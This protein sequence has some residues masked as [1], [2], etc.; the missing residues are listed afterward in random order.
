MIKINKIY[1]LIIITM[2]HILASLYIINEPVLAQSASITTSGSV[3]LDVSPNGNG[4]TIESDTVNVITDC[5]TG[6]NLS[7]IAPNG[8][9]LYK[10]EDDVQTGSTAS[11]TAVDGVHALNDSNNSGKWGFTLSDNPNSN[12][13][14]S[15]ISTTPSVIRSASETA[16]E[17][18]IDDTFSVH[19]GVKTNDNV[20]A[21]NYRM[22]N[23]GAIVY[24]LTTDINCVPYSLQYDGNGADNPNGMGTTSD[25]S[26]EK[27]VRQTN[28]DT[29]TELTLLAPNFKK[30]GHGFLGWSLDKNA[31]T[32]FTDKD[33][34]NDPV[35]YGPNETV[36]ITS[37]ILAKAD[38]DRIITMYAVWIPAL[39]DNYNNPIY[40]QNWDNPNTTLVSD[41]CST[42][43]A[44]TFNGTTG[45]ITPGGI[46]A[47]TDMRDNEVY[48]VAKLAD[49]ECWM[50]E[51]LRLNDQ[52]TK[53]QNQNDATRTNESLAQGYESYDPTFGFAYGSFVGLAEPESSHYTSDSK[54]ENSIYYTSL[55]PG[56][57]PA[58][59]DIGTITPA[60]RFPRYNNSNTVNNVD[61]LSFVQDY[62]NPTNPSP[63]RL[64]E[65]VY[66]YGNYY[67]WSAARA[68]TFPYGTNH[69]EFSDNDVFS[70]CPQNWALPSST[71]P[72]WG[73]DFS[74]LSQA[75]GGT[76]NNQNASGG[77]DTMSKRMRSFPNN[78]MYSGSIG[79][80]VFYR[81]YEGNYISRSNS[82]VVSYLP[83]FFSSSVFN[84]K[85]YR[86]NNKTYGF[87]IRCVAT[88]YRTVDVTM[89]PHVT[90]MTFTNQSYGS[91]TI[92]SSS[93]V[94]LRKGVGYKISYTYDT[95][96]IGSDYNLYVA[97]DP[98]IDTSITADA[99]IIQYSF[100]YDG[101]G[102]DNPNGMGATNAVGRKSVKQ[103]GFDVGT[104]VTLLA[105]N[106]T[107]SDYAF[108][109]WSFDEDAWD[110]ITDNDSTSYPVIFGPNETV[111]ID[112][113][114]LAN[115]NPD[116]HRITLYA[117]WAPAMKRSS[118][119]PVYLQDSDALSFWYNTDLGQITALTDMR[120]NQV[121]GVAEF[122]GPSSTV[123]IMMENLRLD[124]QYSWGV[125]QNNSALCNEGLAQLYGTRDSAH[126]FVGLAESENANFSPQYT[127]NSIYSIGSNGVSGIMCGPTPATVMIDE[128]EVGR[129]LIPRYNN[130]NT[131]SSIE[132]VSY[133]EDYTN[134]S[135]PLISGTYKD[136]NLY[137]YGNYYNF[138]AA[139][140]NTGR[141]INATDSEAA[142][143][144]ICP[145]G[146]T[147]PDYNLYSFMSQMTYGLREFPLNYL[148][149]GQYQGDNLN[150]RG[151]VGYYVTRSSV[152]IS[153]SYE[154]MVYG[155][156]AS[157]SSNPH[158]RT[159]GSSIRCIKN[160]FN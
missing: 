10:Y 109:G 107:R 23:D 48:T 135:T 140:A 103:I 14:F 120:D 53:G 99:Q 160:T 5:R 105:S 7:I 57:G 155:S 154:L 153:D 100:Q 95:G 28:F 63:S 18:D 22:T 143:T 64:N 144:S 8:S 136:S 16:S 142:G 88:S 98:Y 26:N 118:D 124:D 2:M 4:T 69:Y 49:G 1:T 91:Q 37:G 92:N 67:T 128:P 59:I 34:T 41:G 125:N 3:T 93:S 13:V 70:I 81:G 121:Y 116:D 15:P 40:I 115:A 54:D 38:N 62:S 85:N 33:S 45:V 60:Y 101:N 158:G 20:E 51:N 134:S 39:K 132:G 117:V 25:V 83:L 24:Y 94:V 32:H 47:L 86:Q 139:M 123:T 152:S 156:N 21:G 6:Y 71:N 68:S 119:E 145:A 43:T 11:F 73:T 108:I 149:S 46:V 74:A 79:N 30:S 35:I 137:S 146:W 17:S 76:G 111:T 55:E 106:F 27:S 126:M 31:Y 104:D 82:D 80:S 66:G 112:A 78:F 148:H 29:G 90:S 52:Y 138:S 147:L 130:D 42:L 87:S 89:K 36:E 97:P 72:S 9:D 141:L 58:Y 131:A 50:I 114:I 113:S 151:D 129:Y 77:G 56:E 75:Y 19:Y 84:P 65:N 12:T 122:T 96:Y 150:N 159:R 102:A 61:G 133:T 110:H 157:A 44:T 127:G